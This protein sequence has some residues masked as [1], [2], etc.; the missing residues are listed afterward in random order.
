MYS[1]G[2]IVGSVVFFKNFFTDNY[3]LELPT[4]S[5]TDY[6][7]VYSTVV[8]VVEYCSVR[9]ENRSP[10]SNERYFITKRWACDFEYEIKTVVNC[11]R[12]R[13]LNNLMTIKREN[14]CAHV[15]GNCFNCPYLF[16]FVF[17]FCTPQHNTCSIFTTHTSKGE[18]SIY[19][20][21]N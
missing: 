9:P 7:I 13:A 19:S 4:I 1:R 21:G 8:I 18:R 3:T 16:C 17:V 12:L 20:I 14:H 2:T 5:I 10:T 6:Y 15:G 11:T